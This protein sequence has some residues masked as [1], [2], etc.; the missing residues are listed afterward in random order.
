MVAQ[1][2]R[3]IT[4]NPLSWFQSFSQSQATMVGRGF[5]F[6]DSKCSS[7]AS[8]SY[9]FILS[10]IVV[11][12]ITQASSLD[13][14]SQNISS[15]YQH[16]GIHL[17]GVHDLDCFGKHNLPGKKKCEWKPGNGTSE[18]TYT[19]I[20]QQQDK[21]Y[22]KA[23][24]NITGISTQINLFESYNMSVE[25]FENSESTNC[26]KAVFRGS[27]KSLLR[28]GP[29]YKVSF[30]RHSGRLVVNVSWQKEDTKA[31]TYYF[32][33]YKALGSLSWSK[34]PMKSQNG[35]ICTVENLNSSLVYTAQIQCDTNEKCSQ[36]AWSEVYTI[37]SE[38]TTQPVIV[39]LNLTDIAMSRPTNQDQ[40][41][42]Y[43]T[44][45]FPT[46]DLYDGY[47]VT[48]GK[49]SG[50]AYEWMKTT[51]PEITLILSYSAYHLNISAVNNASTS[52]AVSQEIPQRQDMPSM[53]AGKLNVT[54][55]SN[56]SFTIYWKDNLIKECVC[57]SVEYMKKGHKAAYMPFYQNTN[58]YRTL[59]PL[60][61]PL[62]P[63]KRYNITLHT[64]T[65]KETCNMKHV[66]NSERTYGST[67][68]YFIEGSPVSAP[69]NISSYTVT[70]NSVV[71]QWS[72][73]PEEDI[74]GFLLGYI[75]YYTEYNPGG[76]NTERNITVDPTLNSYELGDLKGGTAYKVQ[77][78][79]FTQAGAGVRNTE[80][81][82]KTKSEGLSNL[83]G[84]V[85]V[86][87][88]VAILLIFGSPIIKRA[89]VILW[90]S[91][92]N[93]GKSNALQKIIGPCE[94]ELLESINTLK[95]EEW[96]TYSLQ[97]VEK[98]DVIPASTL[99]LY[100]AFEDEEDSPESSCNWMQRD[101]E[102]ASGGISP[103]FTAETFLD[104]QRTNPQSS[105]FA[106]SSE[107]TTME[108]FQQGIPQG[109][110]ANT[111]VTQATESKPEDT[112]STLGKFSTSPVLDSK[113]I[114]RIL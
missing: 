106:F 7:Y 100:H 66:N 103:V 26:T 64:R 2:G 109:M 9:F 92:P 1:C 93:P 30:G 97:I 82:F 87:A 102:D 104:I 72:S 51:Q 23:T 8:H 47:Y 21:K 59:S 90:P 78:S 99:P 94:L 56:T 16:C 69:T 101:T 29:P 60:P 114:F 70:L 84:V 88:V 10:L 91:I 3:E 75:I 112:D 15:K 12:Y 43:L 34:S 95:A 105:P 74:R 49:A 17:D 54:V 63:Y 76:T 65:D 5:H 44:W 19:L 81:I 111:S 37:P 83:S 50:E 32:V 20:I 40:R 13:C 89:K 6:L 98:E 85:T 53:G 27:P 18:K 11:Y 4:S 14:K 73:I 110:S 67:Q 71:L 68:F 38:L 58:N 31:I 45:K 41:L 42:L 79:G 33:R 48:I 57:Y 22:C 28:C 55:H 61:E 77:I 46:K 113:E 35:E 108:L 24:Y 107:Y 86:F 80:S 96:D 62:E 36:C 25:V 52:P 39:S